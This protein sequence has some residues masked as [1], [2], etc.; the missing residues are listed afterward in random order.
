[1][2]THGARRGVMQALA[3]KGASL[4]EVAESA[5]IKTPRA[6]LCYQDER[7]HLPCLLS[8]IGKNSPGGAWLSSGMCT[9]LGVL[10]RGL[11]SKGS[12]LLLG[13]RVS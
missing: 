3:R 8:R 1:M 9:G 13:A 12:G 11:G 6:A 7:R 2:T 10:R 4:T 5:Q